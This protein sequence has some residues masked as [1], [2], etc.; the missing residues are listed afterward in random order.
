MNNPRVM[1]WLA[2]LFYAVAVVFMVT[3][4]QEFGTTFIALGTVFLAIGQ[5]R[6]SQ[7]NAG[8]RKG[9]RGDSDPTSP[10]DTP[11]SAV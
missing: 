11:P 3:G 9:P 4:K 10:D 1:T 8:S 7:K 2:A 6:P 5:T